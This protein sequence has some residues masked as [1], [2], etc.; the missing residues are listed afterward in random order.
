MTSKRFSSALLRARRARIELKIWL[1]KHAFSPRRFDLIDLGVLGIMLTSLGALVLMLGEIS[2]SYKELN[3]L[4]GSDSWLFSW[5][6]VCVEIFGSND[7]ALRGSLLLTH[8]LN[9]WLM[10]G[11]GRIYL[12]KKRDCLLLILLYAL[13]PGVNISA[14]LLYESVFI[15]FALLLVCYVQLRFHRIPYVLLTLIGL[16]DMVFCTLFIALGIHALLK[17]NTTALMIALLGFG[18]NMFLYSDSIHGVPQAY[19]LDELGAMAMLFSPLVF[20]YY[21]Y[22]LYAALV[23]R[24][25]YSLLI[26]VS[27]SGIIFS[28]L[29]SLRQDIDI[30]RFA[31]ACVVGLPA[32]VYGF[33]NDMRS[34]LRIYRTRFKVRMGVIFS[35]LCIEL[36]CLFGNK[37]SYLFSPEPNFA[38]SYYVAKDLARELEKRNV[39]NLKVQDSRLALRLGFYGISAG[40]GACLYTLDSKDPAKSSPQRPAKAAT[41]TAKTAPPAKATKSQEIIEIRYLG[42]PIA[43]YTLVRDNACRI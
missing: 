41:S 34:R 12:R 24:K 27:V 3:K 29:L 9:M 17:R 15:I 38:R 22:T 14:L 28:L 39:E 4:Y 6:R 37:I 32:L 21:I 36:F 40:S 8:M 31:P 19:F 5:L 33:Y 20:L 16:L 11:I 26:L 43:R 25:D 35:V 18:V 7:Y 42:T 23:R 10:Y 2:V 1:G 30:A 13:L